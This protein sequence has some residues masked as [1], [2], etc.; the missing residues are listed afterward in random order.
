MLAD[1]SA[2]ST[3]SETADSAFAWSAPGSSGS[4]IRVAL[5]AAGPKRCTEASDDMA[6][7][8]L[9][10]RSS[11]V[12]WVNWTTMTVPPEKSTPSGRPPRATTVT[13]PAMITMTD[14]AIACHR[15]LRKLKLGVVRNRMARVSELDAQLGRAS[16]PPREDELEQRARNEDGRKH[17]GD[18]AE[19][20][21]GRESANRSRAELKEK[22]RR[23]EGGDV[24]ID[25]RDEDA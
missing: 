19:E 12:G 18:Q 7:S 25:D 10:T 6:P 14:N 9:R 16:G 17:V 24:G 1:L 4:R 21:R 15:H 2:C 20:E 3:R 5:L 8:A 13:T 11:P 22:R 23:D